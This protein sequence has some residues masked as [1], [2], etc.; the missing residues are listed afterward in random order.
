MINLK[1]F[2]QFLSQ[3]LILK[4]LCYKIK[5]LFID[6]SFVLTAKMVWKCLI[7]IVLYYNSNVFR[8][9][10]HLAHFNQEIWIELIYNVFYRNLSLFLEFV[11]YLFTF[12]LKFCL[13]FDSFLNDF[14]KFRF[15]Q[16]FKTLGGTIAYH[17]FILT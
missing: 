5:H 15:L 14:F 10:L 17:I 4:V 1:L 16:N 2:N 12:E 3:F 8:L 9:Y 13:F 7:K 6:L 11:L